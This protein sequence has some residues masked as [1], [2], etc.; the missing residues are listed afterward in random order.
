LLCFG[1]GS[2]EHLEK[3]C[4][5][6]RQAHVVA[7]MYPCLLRYSEAGSPDIPPPPPVGTDRLRR[8]LTEEVEEDGRRASLVSFYSGGCS[9]GC[10][11]QES[12]GHLLAAREPTTTTS[13]QVLN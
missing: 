12:S 11:H 8:E 2:D 3:Q 10:S 1:C 13:V 6:K 4:T 7:G 9:Q 5:N